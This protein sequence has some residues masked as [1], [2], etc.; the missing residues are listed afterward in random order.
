[1]RKESPEKALKRFLEKVVVP[2][3]KEGCWLWT[4]AKTKDG[5][6][7]FSYEDRLYLPHR[8]L[9]QA[10][11]GRTI[12]DGRVLDHRCRNRNCVNPTHLDCI[13]QQENVV[14]GNWARKQ[15]GAA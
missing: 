1:M 11:R 6:G 10:L 8:W 13:T 4:G 5:Y 3:G 2:D 12:P 15:E 7:R 14:R 9:W